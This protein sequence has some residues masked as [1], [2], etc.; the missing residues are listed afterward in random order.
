[1]YYIF[2]I[3]FSSLFFY[4]PLYLGRISLKKII[5]T[6]QEYNSFLNLHMN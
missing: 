2:L 1:M 3:I 4:F 6:D 5:T